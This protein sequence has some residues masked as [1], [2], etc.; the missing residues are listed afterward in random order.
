MLLSLDILPTY[1]QPLIVVCFSSIDLVSGCFTD[2]DL[3]DKGAGTAM[4]YGPVRC[5][6]QPEEL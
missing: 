1:S 2:V 3:T 5:L 6:Q 4:K